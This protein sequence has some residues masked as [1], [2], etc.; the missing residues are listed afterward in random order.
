MLPAAA[1]LSLLANTIVGGLFERGAFGARDTA[2]VAGAL[3]A[4][5]VGLPGHALEKTFGA[6]SFAHQDPQTPILAALC[7]LAAAV[8]CGMLPFSRVRRIGVSP[9]SA[10]PA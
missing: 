3:A 4:I 1:G 10:S 7:G 9:C 2:A 5:S 8:I 6:V